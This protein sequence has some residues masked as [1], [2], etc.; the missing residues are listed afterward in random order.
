MRQI[1]G[2]APWRIVRNPLIILGGFIGIVY[3]LLRLGPA[4]DGTVALLL[5]SASIALSV[6]ILIRRFQSGRGESAVYGQGALLEGR[7][8]RWVLD[9]PDPE[10]DQTPHDREE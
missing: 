10:Q 2:N 9:E 6:V 8:R 3:V 4:I 7:W 1:N 5:W